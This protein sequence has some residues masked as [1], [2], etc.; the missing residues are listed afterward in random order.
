MDIHEIILNNA[1]MSLELS[2]FVFPCSKF[3]RKIGLVFML[4]SKPNRRGNFS[5]N[6]HDRLADALHNKAD[7]RGETTDEIK[8]TSQGG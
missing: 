7:L 5:S 2:G 8:K 6:K 1:L 3:L 4:I